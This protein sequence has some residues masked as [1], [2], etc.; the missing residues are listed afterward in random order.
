LFV[1]NQQYLHDGLHLAIDRR[2]SSRPRCLPAIEI[3]ERTTM[4][5]TTVG[6]RCSRSA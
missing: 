1:V 2:T 5:S 4:L 6:R 3:E